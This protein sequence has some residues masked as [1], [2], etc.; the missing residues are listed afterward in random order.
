MAQ[1]PG[2]RLRLRALWAVAAIL[3]LTLCTAG[4]ASGSRGDRGDRGDRG[5]R[6]ERRGPHHR[7]KLAGARAVPEPRRCVSA[8]AK[9]VNPN[10]VRRRGCKP[11]PAEASRTPQPLYWGAAIGD[12]VTGEQAPWDMSAVSTFEAEAG[13]SA[14]LIHFFQPFANCEPTCSFYP[15]PTDPLESI[16]A[17]GSIPVLSWSSQSIPSNLE[18]PDFQLGDVIEGRYDDFIR[19]FAEEAR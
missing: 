12:H 2:S 17:H 18:E 4:T 8:R 6:G 9:R 10:A 19:E 15:F 14:S 5:E 11:P 16:R 3:V 1:R 7:A 13:K